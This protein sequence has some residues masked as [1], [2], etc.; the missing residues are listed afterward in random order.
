MLDRIS[1]KE[2]V[3]EKLREMSPAHDRWVVLDEHTIERPFVWIFFY[4][5]ER[6]VTTGN[7]IYRLAGNG[8]VFVN[9]ATESIEFFGSIP[10]LEVI[11]SRY[12]RELEEGKPPVSVDQQ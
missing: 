5:S 9:K 1:A 6:F 12:E 10:P 4:N 2:R 3:S 8:P 7:V 11:V